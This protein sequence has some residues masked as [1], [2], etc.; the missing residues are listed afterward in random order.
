MDAKVLAS[1]HNFAVLN[2]SFDL[3]SRCLGKVVQDGVGHELVVE[4]LRKA[5][6]TE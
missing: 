6:H 1:G 2:E 4:L 3:V 5:C